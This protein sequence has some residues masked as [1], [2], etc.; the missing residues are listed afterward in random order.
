MKRNTFF[1]HEMRG[2]MVESRD[3]LEYQ[4]PQVWLHVLRGIYEGDT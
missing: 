4:F 3:F 2:F 1:L